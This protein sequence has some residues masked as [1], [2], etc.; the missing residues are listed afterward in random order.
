MSLETEL[1]TNF[2]MADEIKEFES[3]T[4]EEKLRKLKEEDEKIIPQ[5][6]EL[7]KDKSPEQVARMIRAA[8]LKEERAKKWAGIDAKT[9]LL[10]DKAFEKETRREMEIVERDPHRG[11]ILALGDLDDFGIYNKMY[12][13]NVGDNVLKALGPKLKRT[14]RRI[15]T[16]SRYGG[17]EFAFAIPF[18][19]DEKDPINAVE[20]IR[21][22]ITEIEI[23]KNDKKVIDP[24][25]ITFGTTTYIPNLDTYESLVARTSSALKLAKLLGKRR[26]VLEDQ[27]I[28][29]DLSNNKKYSLQ[30]YSQGEILVDLAEKTRYTIEKNPESPK[31]KPVL[32]KLD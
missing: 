20:R 27:G 18:S 10:R 14:T 16:V 32:V 15:D 26:T 2:N 4:G 8:Q 12:G 24:I 21:T 17:E 30:S 3:L 28:Y 7:I 6:I 22:N 25:S 11:L 31:A 1:K 5:I 13:Q 29:T 9:G 19:K 23:E